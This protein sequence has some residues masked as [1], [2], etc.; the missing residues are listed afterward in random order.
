MDSTQLTQKIEETQWV[1]DTAEALQNAAGKVL[2]PAGQE[3]RDMLHGVWLG[4]P[5]HPVL[6]DLPIGAWTAA[7]VMDLMEAAGNAEVAPGADAAVAIGLVGAVGAAM[8]GLADWYLLGGK[9]EKAVGGAHA[10]LNTLAAG[11]YGTSLI[12]RRKG[13]R[14]FGQFLSWLG[15]GVVCVSA[16]LGGSMVSE[17]RL[18]VDQAV[19]DEALPQKFTPALADSELAEG[20]MKQ[21]DVE[22][23]KI[24]LARVNSR[25]YAI[26]D[27]C[28]H[29]AGTLS[30]GKLSGECVTC[31][32]HGSVFQI[33]SGEVVHGPATFPV[34]PLET[35]VQNGHIEV[36]VKAT[37]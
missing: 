34:R 24:L 8:S 14:G 1:A 3:V 4:H 32:L 33:T 19:P 20:Q 36:R 2:D 13:A 12:A 17:L 11:L 35:R 18:G 22:G 9:K 25:I 37:S 5:L 23:A 29:R 30:S 16:Y 26:S 15:L 10:T 21:A 28:S 27:V 6:T 7:A 31:P